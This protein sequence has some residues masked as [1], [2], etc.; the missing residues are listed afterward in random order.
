[1]A[2]FKWL[3]DQKPWVFSALN[4]KGWEAPPVVIKVGVVRHPREWAK[5]APQAVW[6]NEVLLNMS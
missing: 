4:W 5:V 6:S 3:N 2:Q 1:M